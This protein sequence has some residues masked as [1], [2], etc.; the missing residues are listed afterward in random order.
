MAKSQSLV[1]YSWQS[2]LPN[3]TNRGFIQDALEKAAK[4]I[5]NDNSIQAGPIIDRDTSGVP[6]SPDI[7]RTIFGKIDQAKVFVCDISIIN[8]EAIRQVD[9]RPTPN[10][11]V[12]LELGYA[13]KALGDKHIIMLLNDAYGEIKLLPFDLHMRRAITYHM[14]EEANERAPERNRLTGILT[15]ALRTILSELDKPLPGEPIEPLSLGEQARDAI[16]KAQPNQN[17]LVRQY[18][19]ELANKIAGMN[20][21]YAYNDLGRCDEQLF[22]ALDES[23]RLVLDF[24]R[25][26]EPIATMNAGEAAKAVYKGFENILNLYTFPHNSPGGQYYRFEHDL[27]KFL[28]HELFVTFFSYLI[29]ENKW[30]LITEILDE[31]LYARKADFERPSMVPFNCLSETIVLLYER[32]ERL[33]LAPISFHA[34]LLNKRHSTGELADLVPM[35]QFAEADYFLFLRAQVQPA[36][37]NEWPIWMPW[38]SLYMH[39]VPRYLQAAKRLNYAQRLLQPLGVEDIQTLQT[40]LVERTGSLEKGW[41]IR[42]FRF[43]DNI[44]A[45]FDF[46]TIGSQ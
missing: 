26:V 32:K 22:E 46:S 11:N 37:V 41:G 10:P 21:S 29:R 13:F 44:M 15:D 25:L 3:S 2:D 30:E 8:Q 7:A 34:D 43:W 17:R 40:R 39:Q 31:D 19:T 5:R 33:Q 14:P 9:A 36:T 27:A 28:G 24:A 23:I 35:D 6:G 4:I 1:F 16:E 42:P 45:G 18:M 20:P 12:L 38:S